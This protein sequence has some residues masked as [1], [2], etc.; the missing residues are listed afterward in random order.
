MNS[1]E[2]DENFERTRLTRE[3]MQ[4]LSEGNASD[5]A[6]GDI[7]DGDYEVLSF[8][9]AGGMGSVYR[10]RHR[11]MNTEYA[12]KTLRADQVT[13][14][15]W[16]RF[17]NEAQAIARMNHPNVVAIYNLGLHNKTVP[18]YV[19]DLLS[20][21]TLADILQA[22]HQLP[23]VEALPI[24][25][26]ACAGIGYAH[27]KGIVHRDIKPGNIVVLKNPDATGAKIKI[28]DFG[29][30]KLSHTKDL[31][32]QQLTGVG[33]ICG[34]PFYMS[35][36]Q[37]QGG[38]V[39]ARS[40]IYSLGC[41]LFETLTGSPPF[42]GRNV[43]ET[44]IMHHSNQPPTL[45]ESVQEQTFPAALEEIVAITLA[46]AP[47]DRYP[48]MEKLQQDLSTILQA[49]LTPSKPQSAKTG[50]QASPLAIMAS[51]VILLMGTAAAI[52]YVNGR[53]QNQDVIPKSPAMASATATKLASDMNNSRA[54]TDEDLP[55]PSAEELNETKPYSSIVMPRGGPEMIHFEFPKD[56]P[57]G[58]LCL[59]YDRKRAF[60]CRGTVEIP[61]GM[62]ILLVPGKQIALYPQ[63]L[64]RF[65]PGDLQAVELNSELESDFFTNETVKHIARLK[66][67]IWLRL[68]L[69]D[70]IDDQIIPDLNSMP[71]L[72]GLTL[73]EDKKLTVLA[74]SRSPLVRRLREL[75]IETN[76]SLTPLFAA[77]AGTP[78][79]EILD[80][81][82]LKLTTTDYR[83][84]GTF[85]NLKVLKANS[86]RLNDEDLA[87]LGK[88][89]NIRALEIDGARITSRSAPVIMAIMTG[90]DKFLRIN[91]EG[92]GA[93]EYNALKSN[94]KGIRVNKE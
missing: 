57:L 20:G 10:V 47:M 4:G 72:K 80:V 76:D 71:D 5:F 53:G 27:K 3:G 52:F 45:N 68:L 22:R 78:N 34:S 73:R 65:R 35:P 50:L 19:M 8:I 30:A 16:R 61:H 42:K 31:A 81:S 55:P 13:E 36:E 59:F 49:E 77:M 12:L 91:D 21:S 38:K 41:T 75:A 94:L 60:P 90:K 2:E 48:N 18:Y 32:N 33:E 87:Q 84:I 92:M 25:I 11:I 64:D 1:G 56:R 88:L 28:V 26:E 85:T 23:V 67:I 82:G 6:A 39:D 83:Y 15:A 40:D 7:I 24:F 70:K 29:I 79:L 54:F 43:T 14:V 93:A 74:L 44:I 66:N 51:V 63:F 58:Y 9:G 86:S 17:Q 46:K 37:S 89:R 62:E 69:C